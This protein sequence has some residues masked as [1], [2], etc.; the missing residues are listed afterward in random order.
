MSFKQAFDRWSSHDSLEAIW[1]DELTEKQSDSKWMEDA[2]YKDLEFGTGGMRGIIGAGTNRMNTY[3]VRKASLG[4]ANFVKR[5]GND[6]GQRGIVIAYD[7]RRMSLSFAKEAAV[8]FAKNDIQTYLYEQPRTTPQLSFSIRELDAFAGV[9]ITASH[10]PPMYNGYKVY[11]QDGAQLNLENAEQ[12]IRFVSEVGDELLVEAGDFESLE[13]S[14]K[15][16]WIG[17]EMDDRYAQQVLSIR[18]QPEVATTTKLTVVFSP[19]H[20]ASGSTVE[21]ILTD[22]NYTNVHFVKEQ[23]EPNGEFPTLASPNPEEESAFEAAKALGN[24][25]SAQLLVTADPDGDRMGIAVKNGHDYTLLN[26]NQTGALL[27]EY[28]LSQRKEAGEMPANGR[29]F[30]TIVTSDLGRVIAEYHGASTEDVLTGFKFIGEKIETYNQSKEFTF[31]FGYEESYG[32]LIRDFARD[33]DAVQAVLGIIEAAAYYDTQ[34]KSLL[35]VLNGLYERHGYYLETLLSETK[36]G[37]DGAREISR[38]LQQ[39]RRDVWTSIAGIPVSY[40]EDYQTQKRIFTDGRAAEVLTLP[41]SNVIKYF[42]QDGSWIC[43]RPS[44]TEPKVKYYVGVFSDTAQ[45]SKDKMERLSSEVLA[46]MSAL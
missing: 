6:A 12:V 13:A 41:K 21:R 8:T 31:L 32:Y 20:G 37:A 28:F 9:V 35:D 23:M 44:G 25:V 34:G 29:V 5:A 42:L 7:S 27:L 26:G 38:M 1:K 24:E 16:K 17:K 2:F 30:K 46:K 15:V 4:L 19:L 3:T 11:G 45:E 40:M 14:G 33:K 43:V 18:L 36:Q 22:A 10:N 39:L